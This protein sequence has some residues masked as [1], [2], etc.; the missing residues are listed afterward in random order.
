M[1][2]VDVHGARVRYRE[3]GRGRPGTPILLVHGAGGSSAAW[4]TTLHRLGR[5][6]HT[7]AVDLPGHGRSGGAATHFTELRDAVGLTAAALCLPPSI[8][9]GH[10]L[11]GLLVLSAALQWP[12][13]VVGLGLICSAPRF[14]V[15]RKL[16]AVLTDDFGHWPDFLAEIGH[17]PETSPDVRRRSAGL[18]AA[19]GQTQTHTDFLACLEYDATPH[20]GEVRV[21]TLVVSG[22]DDLLAA[23]KWSDQLAERIPGARQVRLPRCGHFPM[24]EQPDAFAAAL[25]AHIGVL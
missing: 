10:S 15:S 7:V 18:A 6:R 9:I 14:S 13:K 21:P 19:S 25:A 11:G 17:S 4:L 3:S 24:H 12:D 23:P 1:P 2:F 20:L 16:L 8:L 22:A 5:L